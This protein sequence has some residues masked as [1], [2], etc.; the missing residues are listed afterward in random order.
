V[1]AGAK[2][3]SFR[4]VD[5]EVPSYP[6]GGGT[7]EFTGSGNIPAGAFSYTGPC[8]P[9]GPHT[10]EWTVR[11]LSADRGT[12]LGEGAAAKPFPPPR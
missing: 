8:P 4:M 9:S 7:V 5:R 2:Y 10:Y 3:R 1:P 6:H 12:I 11:A